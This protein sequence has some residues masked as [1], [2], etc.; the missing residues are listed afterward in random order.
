MSLRSLARSAFAATTVLWLATAFIF[1][2]GRQVQPGDPLPVGRCRPRALMPG[3]SG[4]GS[5]IADG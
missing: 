1:G 5:S 2:Q 3:Q 4:I